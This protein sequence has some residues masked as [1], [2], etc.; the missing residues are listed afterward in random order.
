MNEPGAQ[1]QPAGWPDR[2]VAYDEIALLVQGDDNYGVGRVAREI[3]ALVPGLRCVAFC[4]GTE[5]DDIVA[6][7]VPVH[8]LPGGEYFRGFAPRA[9]FLGAMRQ[10]LQA[11][12]HWQRCARELD[13][14]CRREGVRALHGNV[15]AHYLTLGALRRRDPA[16]YRTIWH[17]HNFLNLRRHAGLPGRFN[18]WQV[19]QGADWVLAVSRAVAMGWG[20]SGVPTRVVHNAVSS[21]HQFLAPVAPF[22]APP[23]DRPLR[24]VGAGRM[25]WCKGHHVAIDAVALL[26][27]QGQPA[28]LDLFG[29]P[30]A[31]NSYHEWL[32]RRVR[33]RR[34]EHLVNF[35]GY[36]EDLADRLPAYDLAVQTRI[37]PEPFGLFVVECLNRALPVVASAGGGIPEIIRDGREGLLVPPGDATALTASVA[38]LVRDPATTNRLAEAG[39]RRVRASFSPDVFAAKLGAFYAEVL[40]AARTRTTVV[41]LREAAGGTWDGLTTG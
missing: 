11:R 2:P 25:E 35:R 23:A 31:G 8:V 3:A 41:P 6:A 10:L 7:G 32:R 27:D 13:A 5:S 30:L 28:T 18:C 40:A 26:R 22:T 24:L 20:R 39:R 33:E 34:L 19:R 15:W 9:G 12:P 17:V 21:R 29:G 16:R 14:W 36:V 1:P 4:H 38:R 37:D